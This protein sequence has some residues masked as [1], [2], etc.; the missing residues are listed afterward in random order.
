MY[1]ISIQTLEKRLKGTVV[2]GV[3]RNM[4]IYMILIQISYISLKNR[5]FYFLNKPCDIDSLYQLQV[6]RRER[7]CY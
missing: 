2:S 1:R 5:N 7:L 6:S 4:A 3:V